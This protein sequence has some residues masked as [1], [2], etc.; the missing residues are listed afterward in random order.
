M[1][2][3]NFILI[4][5]GLFAIGI[6]LLKF[7]FSETLWETK[8]VNINVSDIT[9]SINKSESTNNLNWSDSNVL[10]KIQQNFMAI[11]GCEGKEV[12]VDENIHFYEDGMIMLT[13]QNCKNVDYLDAYTYENG[14]WSDPSP[15]RT[16]IHDNWK[17]NLFPLSA[18]R[19]GTVAKVIANY[20]DKAQQIVGAEKISHVYIVNL[21]KLTWYPRSI[22]GTRESYSIEFDLN[23]DIKSFQRD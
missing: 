4:V 9:N 2:K 8:N 12:M 11:A 15:V 20:N 17:S 21:G 13:I 5:I 23:G 14:K 3:K 19:F 16:S 1:L 6:I 10:N 22:D 7:C 18:V